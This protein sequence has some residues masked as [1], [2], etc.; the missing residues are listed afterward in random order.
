MAEDLHG[1]IRAYSGR[2]NNIY[3]FVTERCQLRCDHCYMGDRLEHG[4]SFL[5]DDAIHAIGFWRRMG[6]R[7][8]TFVGGEPTLYPRLPAL[9]AAANDVGFEK[10]MVDTNIL[11]PERL[12]A[13]PPGQ[14]YYVRVSL[15]GATDATHDKVRGHG[16][17]AKALKG[18]KRLKAAGHT[19]RI[20]ST[21]FSF[22]AHEV[23]ALVALCKS[24]GVE[25]LNLHSFTPEGLGA[26]RADWMMS[27]TDWVAFCQSLE[28]LGDSTPVR[29]RYP[30]TWVA[31]HQLPLLVDRGFRGC[32][33]CSLDRLSV[34]PDGG[35]Y[36]CSLLFDHAVH[37]GTMKPGG[38]ELNTRPG[39][40][41]EMYSAA[42]IQASAPS[43]A[44]CPAE[45]LLGIAPSP[46]SGLVSVCR[47]W[48]T[49]VPHT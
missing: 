41:F 23:P 27:K 28:R 11:L 12:T 10:V 32:L 30:P 19:V 3:F 43:L 20:T 48:R 34:F 16:N 22:N 24:L 2:F 7:F 29:V 47:L 15:D 38:F 37:F 4:S 33:G 18:I 35:C 13:I 26:G 31:K 6:G 45:Q 9:V 39:N 46:E 5:A 49:E 21:V 8:L 44:G 40:E 42:A 17:F 36:V 14:L 1:D 25:V